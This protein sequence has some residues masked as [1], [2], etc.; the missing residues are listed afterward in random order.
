M[1]C[2]LLFIIPVPTSVASP[3]PQD[4]FPSAALVQTD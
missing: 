3:R 1:I 2:T 4:I